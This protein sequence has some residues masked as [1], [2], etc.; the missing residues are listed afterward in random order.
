MEC[1]PWASYDL[2]LVQMK[3]VQK[4][5]TARGN[6]SGHSLTEWIRCYSPASP[7]D[8]VQE[9]KFMPS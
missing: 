7:A 8:T 1:M 3:H 9:L 4:G 6:Q 2:V 5:S